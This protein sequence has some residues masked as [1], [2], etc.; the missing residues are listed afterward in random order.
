MRLREALVL[1]FILVDDVGGTVLV[2]LEHVDDLLDGGQRELLGQGVE[3][4][5]A[6]RPE[7]VLALRRQVRSLA[8]LLLFF[9][10]RFRDLL[11][12]VFL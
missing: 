6:V 4:G 5:R 10:D 8:R 2:V 1:R 9:V 3:R 11:G 12:P 7:F